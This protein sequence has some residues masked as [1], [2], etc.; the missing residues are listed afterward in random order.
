MV[1]LKLS[2][3]QNTIMV[4]ADFGQIW[5]KKKPLK[6][7]V[8]FIWSD[9]SYSFKPIKEQGF[10]ELPVWRLLKPRGLYS[11]RVRCV[12]V[13]QVVVS[14]KANSQK[15]HDAVTASNVHI[16]IVI[17][18]LVSQWISVPQNV[19]ISQDVWSMKRVDSVM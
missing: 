9:K 1:A 8:Y 19:Q 13:S 5:L 4:G 18:K 2:Q 12:A 14:K 15:S 11:R 6:L 3:K 16:L 10:N 17:Y 7:K